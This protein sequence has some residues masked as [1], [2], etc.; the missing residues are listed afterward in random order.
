MR[1]NFVMAP[2]E[3][4]EAMLRDLGNGPA[5]I[6]GDRTSGYFRVATEAGVDGEVTAAVIEN[7]AFL[8][9][10]EQFY[11][12]HLIDDISMDNWELICTQAQ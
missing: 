7:K 10:E 8:K 1:S 6:N 11:S 12:I 9:P 2:H 4:D 5:S 3:L